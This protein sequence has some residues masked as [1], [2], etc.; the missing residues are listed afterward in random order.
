MHQVLLMAVLLLEATVSLSCITKA[1]AQLQIYSVLTRSLHCLAA[2]AWLRTAAS[3][4]LEH[5]QQNAVAEPLYFICVCPRGGHARHR[6]FLIGYRALG[7]SN[8]VK[9]NQE[10]SIEVL[11]EES[12]ALKAQVSELQAQLKACASWVPVADASED[13]ANASLVSSLPFIS[14]WTTGIKIPDV[15]MCLVLLQTVLLLALQR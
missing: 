8:V 1:A 12:K 6:R 14:K 3:F 10:V 4:V 11:Q 2:S 7:I 15:V 5:V 13:S 9:V